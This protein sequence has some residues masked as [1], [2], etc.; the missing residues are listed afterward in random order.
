M[1]AFWTRFGLAIA[2][3]ASWAVAIAAVV[4]WFYSRWL[5]ELIVIVGLACF[6]W[7]A[8]KLVR[9]RKAPP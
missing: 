8:W 9:E 1:T 7:L 4:V 6:V 3:F 2:Y 5:A